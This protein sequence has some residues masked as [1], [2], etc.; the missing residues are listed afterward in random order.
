M[1][2]ARSLYHLRVHDLTTAQADELAR[3]IEKM[4]DALKWYASADYGPNCKADVSVRA[5]AVE[6]L[7]GVE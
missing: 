4:Q 7:R 3:V 1:N 2:L 5:R 6:A